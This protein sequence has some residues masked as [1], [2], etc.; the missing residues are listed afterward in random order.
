MEG[1]I[2]FIYG[3]CV[4]LIVGVRLIQLS[5]KPIKWDDIVTIVLAIVFALILILNYILC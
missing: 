5:G 1:I 2:Y 3:L 4:L